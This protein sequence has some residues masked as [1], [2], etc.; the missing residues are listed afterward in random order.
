VLAAAG[1][2]LD[3]LGEPGVYEDFERRGRALADGMRAI[4]ARHGVTGTVSQV[5]PV[6]QLLIGVERVAGFDDFLAADQAFYDRLIVQMLRRGLFTLP[7]GRW[8]ISTAHTDADIAETI[9]IIDESLAATLA[10]GPA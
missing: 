1:A 3:A 4:L 5:G 6:V 9:T 2:T 10:E 7:G 8:Y